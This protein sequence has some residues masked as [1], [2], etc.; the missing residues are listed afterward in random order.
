[1]VA[2]V[3]LPGMAPPPSQQQLPTIWEIQVPSLTAPPT[4]ELRAAFAPSL[5]L[6]VAGGEAPISP[7][8]MDAWEVYEFLLGRRVFSGDMVV[9]GESRW[10]FFRRWNEEMI[11]VEVHIFLEAVSLGMEL[12]RGE[13]VRWCNPTPFGQHKRVVHYIVPFHRKKTAGRCLRWTL[14]KKGKI[15]DSFVRFPVACYQCMP[16]SVSVPQSLPP[17][18]HE[19]YDS[20]R[21]LA[22]SCHGVWTIR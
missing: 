11:Q 3:G 20:A 14:Q 15:Q 8:K 21:L 18:N 1:M 10:W 19:R 4:A 17:K 22:T 7:V 2:F 9:R 13:T 16:A 5:G 6:R 12:G